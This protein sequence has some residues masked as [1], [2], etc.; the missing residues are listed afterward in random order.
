MERNN[1]HRNH[2]WKDNLL[3]YFLPQ[4]EIV[5]LTSYAYRITLFAR[6]STF[7]GIV[8]PICFAAFRLMISSNL[9]G[10]STGRSAGLAPLSI[11]STITAMR[12]YG[13]SWSAPYDIRPPLSTKSAREEIAGNRFFVASSTI[14]F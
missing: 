12:R 13:S 2:D 9:V 4:S 8:R 5:L 11:L 1:D 14:R 6:A 10:C 3:H 7:G